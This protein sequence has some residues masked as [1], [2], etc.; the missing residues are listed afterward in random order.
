V[1][2]EQ[3]FQQIA[4]PVANR[5]KLS[6]CNGNKASKVS[7]WAG[8]L[9]PTQIE[10]TSS[11]LYSALPE[12]VQLKTSPSARFELLEI[13]RP[14]VQSAIQQ[15]SKY[16]LHQPISFSEAAQKSAIL[17][18]ALQKQMID[19]Y[20]ICARD[21][22]IKLRKKNKI[23]EQAITSLHRALTGSGFLFMRSQQIYSTPPS[24]LWK[25]I[26]TLFRIIDSFDLEE[27]R[28]ADDVQPIHKVSSLQAHYW[29]TLMLSCAK[30]QQLSQND[31]AVLYNAFI[32][33]SELLKFELAL[34]KDPDNF[35]YVNLDSD[36][37]PEYK[38]RQKAEEQDQLLLEL[39]FQNLVSQLSKHSRHHDEPVNSSITIPRDMS[40]AVVNHVLDAWSNIGQRKQD[41]RQVKLTADFCVGLSHCH[42]YLNNNQDF[43]TFLQ[44]KKLSGDLTSPVGGLTPLESVNQVSHSQENTHRVEVQNISNGGYCL[45]WQKNQPVKIE[46]GE[47]VCIKEFGKKHWMV[48]VVRWIRQRKSNSQ[49]GIQIITERARPYA[50]AQIYDMGGES[51]FSRALFVPASE[52]GDISASIITPSIPF[53]ENDRV[54]VLDGDQSRNCK[55]D[56]KIFSTSN[57]Q[58]F[59]FHPIDASPK[60]TSTGESW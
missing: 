2:V 26:H 22:L 42:Y 52:F 7:E 53:K 28:I 12:V 51:K 17:S 33:W 13:L 21:F 60:Q 30:P 19:G 45:A 31:I 54:T 27:Q 46:A 49:A 11:L 35:Y 56:E 3:L 5:K 48:G 40:F 15:L 25:T 39:N 50:I 24:G 59:R 57:I 1:Q 37:A 20:S 14:H 38:S 9:R 43:E 55:L 8:L 47:I 44:S 36:R 58:Q 32:E 16:F 10:K 23:P 29:T 6:F 34:S 18:L 41:R 4:L